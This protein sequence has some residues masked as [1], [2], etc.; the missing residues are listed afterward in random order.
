MLGRLQW[1]LLILPFE[2]EQI[3]CPDAL[4]RKPAA[5]GR[6]RGDTT[7]RR[8]HPPQPDPQ[9]VLAAVTRLPREMRRLDP[10][11]LQKCF[12]SCRHVQYVAL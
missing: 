12:E 4:A 2:I 9:Q 8:F 10:S 6:D 1:L 7:P 11:T 3:G 5:R